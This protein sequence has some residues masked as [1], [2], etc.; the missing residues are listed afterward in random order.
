MNSAGNRWRAG[1]IIAIFGMA[2]VIGYGAIMV[3]PAVACCY[4]SSPPEYSTPIYDDAQQP[5]QIADAP[6]DEGT[7]MAPETGEQPAQPSGAPVAGNGE[8][9]PRAKIFPAGFVYHIRQLQAE[10]RQLE[11]MMHI[12]RKLA[13]TPNDRLARALLDQ[14]LNR[15]ALAGQARQ[16]YLS[17]YQTKHNRL[18]F[19]DDNLSFAASTVSPDTDPVFSMKQREAPDT[20]ERLKQQIGILFDGIELN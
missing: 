7:N 19:S 2:C 1:Y 5:D 15:F 20:D 16:I 18:L 8:T 3:A 6:A 13:L 11:A 4:D 14:Q 12:K 10:G 9:Q 17:D